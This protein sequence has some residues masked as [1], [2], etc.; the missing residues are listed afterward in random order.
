MF[1]FFPSMGLSMADSPHWL[2]VDTEK[3]IEKI[4]GNIL[5]LL[6]VEIREKR[7]DTS[8]F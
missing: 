6:F 1:Q 2:S 8:K 3:K 7:V 5:D 4:L